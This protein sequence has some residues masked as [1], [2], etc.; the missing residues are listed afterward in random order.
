MQKPDSLIF[1]MDG[2]LWDAV[3]TYA[4][5]W[6]VVFQEMGIEKHID[7]SVIA[8]MVGWEGKKVI[9]TLMP[10]FDQQK[11]LDIYATVND[12]RHLLIGDMGGIL[13]DGVREGLPLLAQKYKVF[14]LSNCAKG[15]IQQFI[16]WAGI[17]QYITD[18]LA[19]G[20][21]FMPKHHNIKLLTHKH[22]LT[23]PY[24]IGDT[25]G[26]GEQTRLAGIPFVFVSYGFGTTADYDLKFDDFTSLTNYFVNL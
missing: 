12:R 15:I 7:R 21:N 9:E 16:K 10:E 25:A 13:Y 20:V 2:T 5:S 4:H 14:I 23:H 17:E 11:R 8:P 19:Y 18:E 22:K 1:D 24:Y 3:D 6:N 26:D